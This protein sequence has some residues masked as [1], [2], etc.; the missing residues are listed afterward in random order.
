MREATRHK[1]AANEA[2]RSRINAEESAR[3]QAATIEEER[4][5][6]AAAN[7]ENAT[8][9]GTAVVTQGTHQPLSEKDGTSTN[10]YAIYFTTVHV[11]YHQDL[12]E[13]ISNGTTETDLQADAFHW[14]TAATTGAHKHT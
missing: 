1:A 11:S 7:M 14:M 9:N 6:N 2:N 4:M 5:R 3:Q 10:A 12:Q 13:L 8:A